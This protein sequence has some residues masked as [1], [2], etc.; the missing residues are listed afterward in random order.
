MDTMT[1]DEKSQESSSAVARFL[2]CPAKDNSFLQIMD[3]R[4]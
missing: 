2:D 3:V 1:A 4:T